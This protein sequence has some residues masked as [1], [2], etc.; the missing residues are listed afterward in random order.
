MKL[1]YLIKKAKESKSK[2]GLHRISILLLFLK[3][4]MMTKKE[5]HYF[6]NEIETL[7]LCTAFVLSFNRI[8]LLLKIVKI[9]PI[10]DNLTK[11]IT[12][13]SKLSTS[14]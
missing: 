12:Q 3:K 1:G 4:K 13:H 10:S 11:Y 8:C 5:N 9:H 2:S 6:L 7:C 14:G